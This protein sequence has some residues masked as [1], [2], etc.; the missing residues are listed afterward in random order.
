MKVEVNE[1]SRGDPY[2]KTNLEFMLS[3]VSEGRAKTILVTSTIL[4]GKTFISVNLAATFALAKSI[5]YW[6]GY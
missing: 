3:T 2:R 6:Y 4:K 5:A 1:F